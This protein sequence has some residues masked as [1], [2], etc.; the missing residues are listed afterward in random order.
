MCGIYIIS[1][2]SMIGRIFVMAYV[3][4]EEGLEKIGLQFHYHFSRFK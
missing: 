4:N 3:N 1:L 2:L